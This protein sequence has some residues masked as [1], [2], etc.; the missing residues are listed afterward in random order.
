MNFGHW[1]MMLWMIIIA[2]RRPPPFP[3]AG[4]RVDEA[5]TKGATR[6][7]SRPSVPAPALSVKGHLDGRPA[8]AEGGQRELWGAQD[9]LAHVLTSP[10]A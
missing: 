9:N 10:G 1:E 3:L 8:G 5:S 7:I 6:T 4:S 2:S